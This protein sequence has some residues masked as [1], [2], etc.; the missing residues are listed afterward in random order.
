MLSKIILSLQTHRDKTFGE[1]NGTYS[2]NSKWLNDELDIVRNLICA[3]SGKS[4][5]TSKSSATAKGSKTTSSR[6]APGAKSAVSTKATEVDRRIKRKS[7]EQSM[8]GTKISPAQKRNSAEYEKASI[9]A[10]L[11]SDLNRL[12]KDQLL[13]ELSKRGHDT[14]SMK[15]LKKNMVDALKKALLDESDK[16]R[17]GES[18]TEGEEIL[19]ESEEEQEQEVQEQ[20]EEEEAVSTVFTAVEST[21]EQAVDEVKEHTDRESL[22]SNQLSSPIAANG[23]KSMSGSARKKSLMAEYRKELSSQQAIENVE[24]ESERDLR[25]QTE[26]QRRHS[27]AMNRKSQGEDIHGNSEGESVEPSVENNVNTVEAIVINNETAAAVSEEERTSNADQGD[28]G[29]DA[30]T[31]RDSMMSTDGSTWMEVASPQPTGNHNT[32][33]TNNIGAELDAATSPQQ[34]GAVP[35][36]GR[37]SLI[38]SPIKVSETPAGKS[39]GNH[40]IPISAQ[41]VASDKTTEAVGALNQLESTDAS[42]QSVSKPPKQSM[43]GYTAA[44]EAFT[45][46]ASKAPQS[47]QKKGL[48]SFL[49]KG[50]DTNTSIFSSAAKPAVNPNPASTVKAPQET[51]STNAASAIMAESSNTDAA[52]VSK[53]NNEN[54]APTT[55][56]KDEYKIED[57]ESD[58]SASGT[59]DEGENKSRHSKVPEWAR[60]S[61]LKEAL[62]R[63]YGLRGKAPMDPDTIFPE[64]R[65]CSLEEIFGASYGKSGAYNKRSS[66]AHWDADELTMHEKRSYRSQMGFA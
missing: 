9:Q 32:M 41:K 27:N 12:K 59:D 49:S 26:F 57:A 18:A 50:Q 47:V 28:Q 25:L 15:S 31:P 62:E 60:G 40:N 14:L 7:P 19:E 33:G 38:I 22:G 20:K 6:S 52:P 37:P 44:A 48:F 66:S 24:S 16:I 1:L 35:K 53:S 30:A 58:G 11:P 46:S 45:Q 63:Q 43:T 64:V 56:H 23:T 29:E 36:D 42:Y 54:T 5:G 39:D 13:K 4:K 51:T 34:G 2:K 17:Q 65:T 8:S 10:G 55:N 3:N 21:H 61:N